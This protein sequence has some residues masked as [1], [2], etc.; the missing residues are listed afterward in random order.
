MSMRLD[1]PSGIDENAVPALEGELR[2]CGTRRNDAPATRQLP[3]DRPRRDERVSQCVDG[4]LDPEV[5]VERKHENHAVGSHVAARMVADDEHRTCFRDVVQTLDLG[6]KVRRREQPHPGKLI[7]D[8]IGV[9]A[10]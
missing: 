7:A 3:Y 1:V 9:T 10:F 6:P 8:E 4:S 2:G 5:S